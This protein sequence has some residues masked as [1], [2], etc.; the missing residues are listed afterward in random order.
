MSSGSQHPPPLPPRSPRPGSG[1]L[2]SPYEHQTWSFPPP[3]PGPPPRNP[4]LSPNMSIP[5]PPIPPR[6]PGFEINT[7]VYGNNVS[8]R[9]QSVAYTP[10]SPSGQASGGT[11]SLL[12]GS[13]TPTCAPPLPPRP[14]RQQQNITG[15]TSYYSPAVQPS[16]MTGGQ[17]SNG[18]AT[19][20]LP[21]P[22]PGPPPR[23]PNVYNVSVTPQ[24]DPASPSPVS[25]HTGPHDPTPLPQH[26]VQQTPTP[27]SPP[28]AYS[29][30]QE[31]P[32]TVP[33]PAYSA[34]YSPAAEAPSTRNSSPPTSA[35]PSPETLVA[36]FQ[37]LNVDSPSSAPS[38]SLENP[39]TNITPYTEGTT[40][41]IPPPTNG[42]PIGSDSR[43]SHAESHTSQEQVPFAVTSCIDGP[44]AFE[45]DWYQHPGAPDFPIC[46]RCYVDHIYGTRFRDS[47]GR[48]I[49]NNHKPRHCRFSKPRMKDHLFKDAVRSGSLQ[50]V[51]EW[52]RRRSSI[53]DCKGV[54]GVKGD[55]G[56]KWYAAKSNAIPNFVSCQACYEDCL[57]TNQFAS[58]FEPSPPQPAG[59]TWACDIAM[60]YIQ[61]EYE[62]KGQ[63]NDW[64]GF[65]AEAKARLSA[66][67]CPQRNKVATYGK[68]WFIPTAGPDE[69]VLCA[70][71]Y[72]DH[73]LHTGEEPKWTSSPA[74]QQS[75]HHQTSCAMGTLPVKLAMA[76]A[77]DAKNYAIFWS[78]IAQL[79]R[80]KPCADAG[81]T[82]GTWYTLPSNP[83]DFG[84]CAACHAGIAAPLGLSAHFVRKPDVAP[85]ATLRC[86]LNPAHPRKGR[87]IM[88]LLEAYYLRGVGRD[89]AAD[90]GDA[91]AAAD[92]ARAAAHAQCHELVLHESR[93]DAADFFP[94]ALHVWCAGGGVRVRE[95]A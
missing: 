17:T 27:E 95:Y 55:V 51:L 25:I 46:S 82:D 57:C 12:P 1:V 81:I 77:H 85:G 40:H 92:G 58:L 35:Y 39:N 56:I 76:C 64:T 38:A 26:A 70:A 31:L 63:R 52:M 29:P 69:L 7:G 32:E 30:L 80:A 62:A 94:W 42:R 23:S 13:T 86:C 5:P 19:F 48:E 72:C 33:N 78:A 16:W 88:L 24:Y 10:H 89:R 93:T 6:P 3:P 66:S 50:Q 71:C 11:Q 49:S 28:P 65:V 79:S 47:F 18:M 84:L 91:G 36:S 59:D 90:A 43:Q 2:S 22:P 34:Y 14:Q 4:G 75:T 20:P 41:S 53:P 68:N 44:M 87:F 83:P 37:S 45:T 21:P 74:L 8:S 67:P 73:V 61:K 54:D 15:A 9:P 60:P